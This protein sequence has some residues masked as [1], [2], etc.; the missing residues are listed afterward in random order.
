[1][2]IARALVCEPRVLLMDEPFAALDE[3]TRERLNDELLGWSQA[4]S[5]T[6]VF[7]THSV[8]EAVYLSRRVVVMSARPG[9][10]AADVA[11]DAPWPRNDAF[12]S[13]PR[14]AELCAGVSQLLRTAMV[15]A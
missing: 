14:Y 12:R 1:V 3:L 4:L 2:S 15:A 10:I 9:R 6:T 7:V 8:F 11:V 5:L 13:T